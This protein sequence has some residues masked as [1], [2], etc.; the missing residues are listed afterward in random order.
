MSSLDENTVVLITGSNTGVGFATVQSLLSPPVHKLYTVILTSRS[1]ER[2][3]AAVEDI[4]KDST[5]SEAMSSG[6]KVVPMQL[7]LE[8]DESVMALRRDIGD[9]Y[10]KIDVL[11]NNAGMSAFNV[12]ACRSTR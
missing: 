7:D 3:M 12:F 6:C 1:L 5:F 11:V 2:S 10:G 4:R 8:D 9:R